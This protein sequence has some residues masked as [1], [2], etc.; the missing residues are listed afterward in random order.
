MGRKR[1]LFVVSNLKVGGGAEKSVTMLT[2]GLKKHYDVELLTFYDFKEEYLCDVK[3]YSFNY[4]YSNST[5]QKIQRLLFMFPLKLKRFLKTHK[6]DLVVSNAEDAN[7]VSLICKKYF[8]NYKLWTVIRNDIFD[9][10]HPYHKFNFLQKHADKRIVLTKALQQRASFKTTVLE[11]AIEINEIN[12]KKNEAVTGKEKDLFKKKTIVMVGR[13]APQKN[14]S[15]FFDVFKEI[16]HDTNLLVIGNGPLEK[17]LKEKAK[18]QK[19]IHFLGTKTNVYK[20]LNKADVFVLPSL[21]EGMPRVLMEALACGC[22]CV[23][24]DCE[25]G[26]RELLDVRLSKELKRY[27]KTKYGY[28]VPF[29]NKE[30]FVKALNDAL[31]KGKRIEPDTRFELENITKKWVGEIEK[32]QGTYIK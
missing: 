18:N 17:E 13:L 8:K 32:V 27:E 30:E 26:P 9:K 20:Y 29:N 19:N 1:I 12:K 14:Y 28:L 5:I 4:K 2:K 25:T 6:Y 16:K 23:A 3:R 21:F 11:N 31:E 15:W 22:V 24:N 10:K 7:V